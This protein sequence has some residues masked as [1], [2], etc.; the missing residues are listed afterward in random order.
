M[1]DLPLKWYKIRPVAV[2]LRPLRVV[3]PVWIQKCRCPIMLPMVILS[4]IPVL[5][6][7]AGECLS[8]R[9]NIIIL[10]TSYPRGL[11]EVNQ[12]SENSVKDIF[13][14]L[15]NIGRPAHGVKCLHRVSNGR[16]CINFGKKNYR[17]TFAKKSSFTPHF[18]NGRPQLST[19]SNLVYIAAYYTPSEVADEAQESPK[20]VRRCTFFSSLQAS[21]HAQYFFNGIRVFGT[22]ISKPVP[23]FLRFGRYLV[24]LKHKGQTRICRKCSRPGHQARTCPNILC[25]NCE[26]LGNM[27]DSCPEEVHC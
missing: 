15:R 27:T 4:P 10:T 3:L 18:T 19:S 14:D 5:Y 23:S 12:T 20:P 17:N 9:T 6:V 22:E 26:E 7:I 21:D 11:F 24:R 1:T 2:L 16:F 25:C 13:Q 8:L